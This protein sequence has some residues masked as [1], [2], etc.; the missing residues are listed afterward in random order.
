MKYI[1][2]IQAYSRENYLKM[3]R[4]AK[5][6]LKHPFIVP[7]SQSYSDCLWDWDSW[8]TNIAVRQ[9][10]L[11][12]GTDATAF[13]ECEKGCILNFLEHTAKDG[14]MPI[15]IFPERVFP[16]LNVGERINI[17]KPCLA[18][19]AAFVIR[20]NDGDGSWLMAQFERLQAYVHYYQTQLYHEE[21]GLYFWHDDT[22][23]RAYLGV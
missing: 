23:K 5:G 1:R 11:D 15:C 18:Q 21:T 6:I 14:K 2:E 13:S 22:S 8:L 10:M 16:E 12:N 17:H 4:E 9:I 19:H 3:T 7:G 20:E